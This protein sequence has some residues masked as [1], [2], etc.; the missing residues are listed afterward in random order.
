MAS[1]DAQERTLAAH[2][3]SVLAEGT[4]VV[5]T[6]SPLAAALTGSSEPVRIDATTVTRLETTGGDAWRPARTTIEHS[7]G[8]QVITFAPGDADGP[9][10]LASLIDAAARGEAAGTPAQPGPDEAVPGL[11]FVGFDVETANPSWGSI[12]Q[13]GLVKVIDGRE[14]ERVSWL[15]TPPEGLD[16]FDD[17]NVSIHGISAEIVEHEPPV[18]E[19]ID[20]LVEFVGD[21]PLVAHNAQFDASALRDASRAVGREVPNLM[22]GCTLAQSRAAKL[23]VANHRLPTLARHFG[24]ALDKPHD[25]CEDA[26]ACAGILVGLARRAGHT[27]NLMDFVHSTGFTMGVIAADRVTPVLRDRSGA[28]RAMQAKSATGAAVIPRGSNQHDTGHARSGDDA[29]ANARAASDPQ[30]RQRRGPAPWQSVA[31]PDTI[32]DPAPDAD[33]DSPLYGHNVTLTGEFEPFDKGRL[34]AGIAEQGGQVG[35]NVT[36]KTTIL[37]TG[38]WATVTSKEKR[39]R[40]LQS[41]G[42]DIDIWP[43]ERLLSVLGLDAEPPF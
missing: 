15:C 9:S 26:A 28:A 11:D 10:R 27:G 1:T 37:V 14:V 3:V 8:S 22:F 33:P 36:K 16:D 23:E 6:P 41:K 30:E 24:V 4:E 5:L 42:Q 19:R 7:G 29:D 2:G 21:L 32:P 20:A 40:E 38:E 31:T 13:I 34:W 35:K 12:C 43:A 17:Y 25:A 39:A 18:A